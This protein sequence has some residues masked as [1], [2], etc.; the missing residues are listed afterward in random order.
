MKKSRFFINFS[1]EEN[2]LNDMAKQ[3]YHLTHKKGIRYIFEKGHPED[4]NIRVDYH[5]FNSNHDDNYINLFEDSGWKHIAGTKSTSSHY[6]KQTDTA[7]DSDIFSDAASKAGRYQRL[8]TM[9]ITLIAIYTPLFV[10]AVSTRAIPANAF[11]N[12]KALYLTPGLWERSGEAFWNAF[13]IETP[14][15]LIRGVLW[16]I[17]PIAIILFVILTIKSNSL[18]KKATQNSEN[19]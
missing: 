10:T 8:S 18:Y 12:P 19:K 16:A 6:F 9:F 1:K 4:V 2:W 7:K 5:K 15:S 3:G 14:F 11:L 17:L 13:W